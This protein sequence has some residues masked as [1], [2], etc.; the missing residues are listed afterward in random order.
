MKERKD[1]A[2]ANVGS[3]IAYL[4]DGEN[5]YYQNGIPLLEYLINSG[6]L[7]HI[8]ETFRVPLEVHDGVLVD[9]LYMISIKEHKYDPDRYIRYLY[10]VPDKIKGRERIPCEYH[11]VALRGRD[12]KWHSTFYDIWNVPPRR[13]LYLI[14]RLN[15]QVEQGYYYA[16]SSL[17]LNSISASIMVKLN[18]DNKNEVRDK[19]GIAADDVQL[20]I[21]E[22][23]DFIISYENRGVFTSILTKIY[24]YDDP[25]KYTNRDNAQALGLPRD[26][27]DRVSDYSSKANTA[28]LDNRNKWRYYDI[29]GGY[30]LSFGNLTVDKRII[31]DIRDI[32]HDTPNLKQIQDIISR[33]EYQSDEYLGEINRII[34]LRN[35]IN[36]NTVTLDSPIDYIPTFISTLDS[37]SDQELLTLQRYLTVTYMYIY[38]SLG[39][40][41]AGTFEE[42]DIQSRINVEELTFKWMDNR[43]LFLGVKSLMKRLPITDEN[44]NVVKL[45]GTNINNFYDLSV[46]SKICMRYKGF[47][48]HWTARTLIIEML[49]YYGEDQSVNNYITGLLAIDKFRENTGFYPVSLNINLEQIPLHA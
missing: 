29:E 6:Q 1:V 43:D 14:T 21:G 20:S 5:M 17:M 28:M 25:L 19:Y 18:K 38:W 4:F 15:V 8:R 34:K 3:Q 12:P 48:L 13:V 32:N 24:D 36:Y 45:G 26:Y 33:K 23:E 39:L 7:D 35:R 27:H 42:L 31:Y 9:V 2:L 30:K 22:I 41:N 16:Y 49:K 10:E 37:L 40:T 46:D 47:Y 11:N 44:G